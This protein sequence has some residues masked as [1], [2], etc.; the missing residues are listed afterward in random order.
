LLSAWQHNHEY[1]LLFP[2][3]KYIIS[4]DAWARAKNPHYRDKASFIPEL[5]VLLERSNRVNLVNEKML[6]MLGDN[7]MFHYTQGHTPG[8]LHTEIK[9]PDNTII[10]CSDLIPASP[11]V[12]LPITMG[13]DRSPELLIDEKRQFLIYTIKNNAK[14]FFTHDPSYALAGIVREDEDRFIIKEPIKE[15]I[16]EI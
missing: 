3:A 6:P 12:H 1:D 8:L 5:I 15:F 11:W 9:I 2:N 7:Y 4:H 10:F 13:Y 16:I 14:L